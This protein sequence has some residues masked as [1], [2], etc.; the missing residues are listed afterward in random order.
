MGW[1]DYVIAW[2]MTY[3]GVDC[4][5]WSFVYQRCMKSGLC[6]ELAKILM[7]ELSRHRCF[8]YAPN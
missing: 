7:N 2:L 6:S 3:G 8:G 4:R 5:L 1:G